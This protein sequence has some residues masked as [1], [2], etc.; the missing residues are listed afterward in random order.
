MIFD[1]VKLW[2]F[3]TNYCTRVSVVAKTLPQ[4]LEKAYLLNQGAYPS[5]NYDYFKTYP[6]TN[7]L[8]D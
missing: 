8:V 3:K 1:S 5:Y 2:V 6:L 4:A 7:Q